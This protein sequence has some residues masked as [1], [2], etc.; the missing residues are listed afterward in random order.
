MAEKHIED[1]WR[2]GD[3]EKCKLNHN[4]YHDTHTRRAKIKRAG[5]TKR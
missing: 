5:V 2:I 1:A 3:Q 4:E